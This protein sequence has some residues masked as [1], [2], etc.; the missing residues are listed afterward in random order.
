[1]EVTASRFFC[2]I[3]ALYNNVRAR[4]KEGVKAQLDEVAQNKKADLPSR[5]GLP[6]HSMSC[7]K[8]NQFR[9]SANS[10]PALNFATFFAAITIFSFV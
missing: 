4:L 2:P 7:F 5:V 8:I 6:H 10:A 3:N 9:D 1:M